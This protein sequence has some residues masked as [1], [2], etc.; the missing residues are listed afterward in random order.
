M[1]E[2]RGAIENVMKDAQH[3]KRRKHGPTWVTAYQVLGRLEPALR[4]AL[5][6]EH[7]GVGGLDND[8]DRGAGAANAVMRVL[9]QLAREDLVAIDYF[10]AFDDAKF[11]VDDEWLRPGDVTC[12]IYK[13]IGA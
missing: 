5:V 4:Q 6:Q 12:A 3:G 2:L 13:W 11:R 9:L 8:A 1:Q 10:D 7:G